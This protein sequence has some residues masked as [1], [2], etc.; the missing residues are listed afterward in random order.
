MPPID[1]YHQLRH[2]LEEINSVLASYSTIG[3]GPIVVDPVLAMGNVC[4]ASTTVGWSFTLLSFAKLY[5]KLHGILFDA[6]KFAS[7]LWGDLYY[8]SDI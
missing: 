7:R 5:V 1:A 6:A 3:Q 8:H 2:T 4:F